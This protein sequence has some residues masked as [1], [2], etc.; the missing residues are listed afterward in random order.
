[1]I[2]PGR[3]RRAIG[4]LR[5]VF[6]GGIICVLDFKINSFDVLNDFIGSLLIAVG[7]GM[8]C[9]IPVHSRYRRVMVFV[10]VMA[11]YGCIT[12]F[13]ANFSPE[14][15]QPIPWIMGLLSLMGIAA[16]IAFCMAMRWFCLEAAL[17]RSARSWRTTTVLAV[18][19]YAI[20]LGGFYL[21]GLGAALAGESF[22][23]N[24]GKEALILLV[25]LVPV[26]LAPL[27]HILI[28]TSRMKREAAAAGPVTTMGGAGDMPPPP[29]PGD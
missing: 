11:I 4:P 22:R 23:F 21:I 29:S 24:P 8:L 1:M 7:V 28:S 27:I 5:L 2:D 19:I 9:S 3:I 12:D 17:E 14:Y 10:L 6:W 18:I 16:I 26:F 25:V 15:P 20:P 13:L